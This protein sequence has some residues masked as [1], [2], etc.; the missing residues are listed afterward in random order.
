MRASKYCSRVS[1]SCINDVGRRMAF[2]RV[3]IAT[4]QKCSRV[5]PYRCMCRWA[6]TANIWPGAIRPDGWM[7]LPSGDG[8]A[9]YVAAGALP[10]GAY[11]AP[12]R[13][14]ACCSVITDTTHSAMP[15]DD[16]RRREPDRS[17]RAPAAAR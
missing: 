14:P 1:G 11:D 12:N 4:S 16:R 9:L 3:E 7:K 6:S 15:L 10:R 17:R 13:L 5:V 8:G 2:A